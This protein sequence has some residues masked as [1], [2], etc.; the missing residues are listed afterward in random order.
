MNDVATV[1][2]YLLHQ[3][4]IGGA[5]AAVF[6]WVVVTFGRAFWQTVTGGHKQVVDDS[7]TY[8]AQ[9]RL[10]YEG[11][12]ARNI[13]LDK[14]MNDLSARQEERG[15]RIES[16]EG[17]LQEYESKI[18]EYDNMSR[19]NSYLKAEIAEIREELKHIKG[20]LYWLMREVADTHPEAVEK[21]KRMATG[22]QIEEAKRAAVGKEIAKQVGKDP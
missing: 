18:A 15:K 6:I 19:E 4:A 1:I 14:R 5:I 2:D 3:S 20:A 17:R 8:A 7:V 12:L 16:L 9:W 21:A 13:D 11:Q 10:L 22:E